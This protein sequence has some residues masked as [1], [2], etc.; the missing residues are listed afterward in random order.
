MVA[1]HD[2]VLGPR[3]LGAIDIRGIVEIRLLHH[4]EA[5]EPV[6]LEHGGERARQGREH[7][8]DDVTFVAAVV[9]GRGNHGVEENGVAVD[10]LGAQV[11]FPVVGIAGQRAVELLGADDGEA[12]QLGMFGQIRRAVEPRPVLYGEQGIG[13]A[14]AV[15]PGADQAMRVVETNGVGLVEELV[16]AREQE[17][18]RPV[19]SRRR[20]VGLAGIEE[21]VV[22]RLALG[23]GAAGR[24]AHHVLMQEQRAVGKDVLIGQADLQVAVELETQRA[25]ASAQGRVLLVDQHLAESEGVELLPTRAPKLG[26]SG[27]RHP[28]SSGR[29]IPQVLIGVRAGKRPPVAETAAAVQ[30]AQNLVQ[31]VAFEPGLVPS[32]ELRQPLDETRMSRRRESREGLVERASLR[33]EDL[34]V[35]HALGRG[36]GTGSGERGQGFPGQQGWAIASFRQSVQVDGQ[37]VPGKDGAVVGRGIDLRGLPLGPELHAVEAETAHETQEALGAARVG[38]ATAHVVAGQPGK[39]RIVDA[40]DQPAHAERGE[41]IGHG[42]GWAICGHAWRL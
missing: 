31:A 36:G 24:R 9:L 14:R 35:V 29:R 34:A 23:G 12:G 21:R 18:Q 15:G 20:G 3:V 33:R 40:D 30:L 2:P 25:A 42:M 5:A 19:P 27:L 17:A 1:G 10:L 13:T 22:P 8:A 38:R 39:G 6:A 37:D 26:T 11:A 41:R 4:A 32:L 28:L 16:D 7:L